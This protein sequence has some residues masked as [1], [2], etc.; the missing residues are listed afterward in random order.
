V[1]QFASGETAGTEADDS[2]DA[3]DSG[4]GVSVRVPDSSV[5]VGVLI[6]LLLPLQALTLSII[7]TEIIEKKS[8][9]LA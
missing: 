2:A 1:L 8:Y 3:L 4:A 5:D 9:F 7:T 6:C